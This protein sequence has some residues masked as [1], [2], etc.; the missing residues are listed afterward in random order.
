MRA[1]WIAG[2]LVVGL[3]GSSFAV[4]GREVIDRAQKEHGFSTWKDRTLGATMHSYDAETMV[5]EREISVEEQT[6]PKGDHRTFIYFRSPA[7]VQGTQF[8]HLSPR[9]KSDE[10]WLWTPQTG[11]AR[12]L[13]EAQADENFFG[14]D[15]SYRDL[16]LI[17]R[18]QQWTDAE[19]TA[20]LEPAAETVEG[21]ECDVV[22]LVPADRAEFP[23]AR[24]RLWFARADHLL[25]R[26]DVIDDKDVVVKRVLP[27]RYETVG[28]YATA[29]VAEVANVPAN[30]H[31]VFSMH[32]VKYDVGLSD[33]AFSLSRLSKGR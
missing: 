17:V 9:G 22:T 27:K 20:T 10:Q 15:L 14:S 24:Y 19:A 6:D 16:E 7:D 3:V 26:V 21:H 32:E 23:Y 12:R 4:S 29:M 2:V 31:T 5:R 28:T 1:F 18:I 25:W 30:T 8:L 33:T 13:A 11:R